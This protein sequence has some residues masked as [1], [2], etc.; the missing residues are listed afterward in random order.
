MSEDH[1]SRPSVTPRSCAP[2]CTR[3]LIGVSSYARSGQPPTFSIPVGYIDGVRGAGGT[4]L[5]LPP[6]E[7]DPEALLGAIDGLIVSGGGDIAPE[8]YGGQ[9]HETVYSVCE[10]RDRFEF[11]LVRHALARPDLPLLC[12][13]RGLQL[14][15]VICG[16]TLHVHI[17]ERYGDAVAHR[18][19]PRMPTRH[20][21]RV[22]PDSL[23]AQILGTT[24]LEACSFH[25]Q[26]IDRLGAGLRPVAW[27]DDGVIEAVEHEDHPW[28]IGVQWHPE[29]QLAEPAPPRLFAAM[30]ARV[31]LAVG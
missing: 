14:L 7:P 25:H 10:E 12:I 29:M 31:R 22:D 11:A 23:L 1:A 13:C 2:P 19:P 5:V 21:I 3:P 18:L 20:P 9:L 17:P 16:G 27:A 6:G 15:N 28:C 8:A 4:P 24:R 30:I 26:G